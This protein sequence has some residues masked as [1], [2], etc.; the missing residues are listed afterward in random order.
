MLIGWLKLFSPSRQSILAFVLVICSFALKAQAASRDPLVLYT[1]SEGSGSLVHDISGN[2]TP[3]D[4]AIQEP[5]NT[6]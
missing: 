3:M 1:F 6:H 4:L 5:A 2:G